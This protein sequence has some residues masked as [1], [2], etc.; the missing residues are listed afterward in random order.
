MRRLL[1][2]AR[3]QC[4]LPPARIR[5]R[6]EHSIKVPGR[7]GQQIWLDDCGW[8][9][10]F[11]WKV[12]DET[13]SSVYA[14]MLSAG[15]AEENVP[16]HIVPP[17][18]RNTAPIAVLASTFTYTVYGNHARPEWE[19]DPAWQAAWREQSAA[20]GGYPHNAGAHREYGLSTYNRHTDG[21]GISIASWHRPM[22]NVRIGYLTY[23]YEEIRGSGL[24]HF[25]AD[26]HLCAWLEAKGHAYDVI[27][28]W[29]LHR[30][31][32]DLLKNYQVVMTGSHP[33]YHTRAMLDA[34]Q[35]Y[36]NAGGRFCYMGGNGFYWK[37]AASTE[38]DGV[39]EIRRRGRHS[40]LGGGAR[41]ILQPVRRRIWRPVA[42]QR[43]PAAGSLRRRLFRPGQLR[44]LALYRQRGRARVACRLDARRGSQT[45]PSAAMVSAAMVRPASN[46]TAPTRH[47]AHRP[48]RSF[49]RHRKGMS[50]KRPWVLVPE[51]RLTH[52][53]NV[54]GESE[55]ELIRS[56]I[57]FF[58]TPGGGAVFSVGSITYCG[59]LLSDDG[60]N[61]I[62][63]L[64][65]NVL[66]RFADSVAA[67]RDAGLRARAVRF[68]AKALDVEP[69][70]PTED[71][72]Q[73]Y[74]LNRS[75]RIA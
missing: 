13:R 50:R 20:W 26:S 64:T 11:E 61:D 38:R 75:A 58:E 40:R 31:G 63:R 6:R 17:K 35:S 29:E 55:P 49:W 4:R 12:P 10:A 37:I 73:S 44:W 25:P 34:L 71:W 47:L 28:D 36:R 16:F 57:V 7:S 65:R 8:P 67:V 59:S 9:A 5:P 23:P 45:T 70:E 15:G 1:R 33:E 48:M 32:V 30:E 62:A 60:D 52:L 68:L 41:R 39:I 2:P 3:R 56:D 43:T 42:A 46:W 69:N 22:L 72:F 54:S 14:L 21:S 53:T 18:G 24:R 27:T 66:D 51:E 19:T 74:V